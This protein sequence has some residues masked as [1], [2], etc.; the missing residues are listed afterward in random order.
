ME[1]NGRIIITDDEVLIDGV[2]FHTL[3]EINT[4]YRKLMFSNCV[5]DEAPS[6]PLVKLLCFSD[7]DSVMEGLGMKCA[8]GS[9][10]IGNIIGKGDGGS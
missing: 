10:I 6:L 8:P 7:S 5:V 4:G 2:H 1:Y 3:P 9:A